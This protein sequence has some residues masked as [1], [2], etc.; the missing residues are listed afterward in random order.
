MPKQFDA[1]LRKARESIGAKGTNCS[2]CTSGCYGASVRRHAYF[3]TIMA[4]NSLRMFAC[5][6]PRCRMAR[7]AHCRAEPKDIGDDTRQ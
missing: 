1:L 7:L 2:V 4:A 5:L 6:A 3:G